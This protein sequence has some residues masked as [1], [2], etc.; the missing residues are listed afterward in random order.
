MLK[1]NILTLFLLLAFSLVKSQES[2]KAVLLNINKQATVVDNAL[3]EMNKS[4]KN[5]KHKDLA[6]QVKIIES[7]IDAINKNGNALDL[8]TAEKLF[9]ITS[10][11]SDPLKEINKLVNKS[12]LF[13]KDKELDAAYLKLK[14]QQ[15]AF[16]EFLRTTYSNLVSL[17]AETE[18]KKPET[19]V[20]TQ[21]NKND[22]VQLADT[23]AA[24]HGKD[25]VASQPSNEANKTLQ[26]SST[27][28]STTDAGTSN[29]EVLYSIKQEGKKIEI[30]ID[31]IHH[32]LK[33]NQNLKIE[34]MAKNIALS[35]I[36][37]EDLCLLLKDEQKEN[38]R[39]LAAGLKTYADRLHNLSHKGKAAHEQVHETVEAIETKF[40]SLSTGISILK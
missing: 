23:S 35:A 31:S 15:A 36:K 33:K 21:T 22:K 40:S 11:F 6:Q 25:T 29:P 8:E 20:Q 27:S 9:A 3:A 28:S 19:Q 1:Q 16:R 39:T 17:P 26:Q 10:K 13:D 14:N 2:A 12:G 38:V 32:A 5:D 7:T 24:K 4:L 37:I 18:T 30:Y 34:T